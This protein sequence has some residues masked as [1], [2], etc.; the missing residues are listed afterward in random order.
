MILFSQLGTV[1]DNLVN[2]V[3]QELN[4]KISQP[5]LLVFIIS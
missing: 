3:R 2:C 1:G 5:L 4:G